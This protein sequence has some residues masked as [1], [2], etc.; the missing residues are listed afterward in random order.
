V[1]TRQLLILVHF[2]QRE[3]VSNSLENALE[4]GAENLRG[5]MVR[6][7]HADKKQTGAGCRHPART[8]TLSSGK[9]QRSSGSDLLP[10]L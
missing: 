9:F 2:S 4:P 10:R 6:G 8:A 5:L 3:P 7:V 1:R